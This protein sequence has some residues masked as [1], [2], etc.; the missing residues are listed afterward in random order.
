MSRL[1]TYLVERQLGYT[2]DVLG[3]RQEA[4][5]DKVLVDMKTRTASDSGESKGRMCKQCNVQL[6]ETEVSFR[7]FDEAE[8]HILRCP[9]CDSRTRRVN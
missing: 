6:E 5:E 1:E 3:L 2:L 9:V 7:S 8:L 4:A